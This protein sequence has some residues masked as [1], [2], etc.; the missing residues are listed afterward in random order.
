MIVDWPDASDSRLRQAFCQPAP[1]A[2]RFRDREVTF[3]NG[4]VGRHVNV[5]SASPLNYYQTI[6]EPAAMPP[7]TIDGKLFL[8]SRDK[9]IDS[10]PVDHCGPR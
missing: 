1:S 9:A 3:A 5:P 2:E 10:L 7:L 4:S 6:S 8:A